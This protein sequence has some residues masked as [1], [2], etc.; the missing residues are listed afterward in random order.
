[1]SI[2]VGALLGEAQVEDNIEQRE[3][4]VR[5]A[6]PGAILVPPSAANSDQQEILEA[7]LIA[8][9]SGDVG[10]QEVDLG[11]LPD[12]QAGETVVVPEIPLPSEAYGRPALVVRGFDAL[13]TGNPSLAVEALRQLL[14]LTWGHDPATKESCPATTVVFLGLKDPLLRRLLHRA[15]SVPDPKNHPAASGQED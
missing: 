10:A 11:S 12:L 5:F 14:C 15:T 7:A 3:L 1:M 4:L 9:V 2:Q 8:T 13:V 6:E